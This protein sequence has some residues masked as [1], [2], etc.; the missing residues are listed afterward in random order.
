LSSESDKILP[1]VWRASIVVC[2]A[3][4]SRDDRPAVTPP[5]PLAAPTVMID[6][7]PEATPIGLDE[8]LARLRARGYGVAA[9]TIT[10][11]AA[12]TK[13]KMKL[14]AGDALATATRLLAIGDRDAFR[15]LHGVMPR[16]LVE[17]ARAVEQ[18]GLALDEAERIARYLV[19][20]TRALAFERPEVFDE[21]HSH[22]TGREWADIDYT[23]EGI[24]WQS[25]QAFWQPR[26][27]PSF[28]TRDAIHAYFTGAEKLPHWRKVY[29]PRGTMADVPAPR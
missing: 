7:A 8:A 25:Q 13:P 19:D 9:D 27:V 15:E 10:R 17:L 3:C 1:K 28:K 14:P 26:G 23:G 24:T 5:P 16:S 4:G 22:V 20:V 12:Q 11:R 21:N 18:R 29:R 2:V 6:A